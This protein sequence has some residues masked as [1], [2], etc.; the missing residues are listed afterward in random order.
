VLAAGWLKMPFWHS[1]FWIMVGKGTRYLLVI[2]GL[3]GLH[4]FG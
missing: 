1:L 3:K 4:A 2:L